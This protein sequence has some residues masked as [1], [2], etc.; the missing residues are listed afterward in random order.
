[1]LL[2]SLLVGCCSVAFSISLFPALLFI[3]FKVGF[4]LSICSR[5]GLLSYLVSFWWVSSLFPWLSGSPSFSSP[6][7][8]F[9]YKNKRN[10]STTL[11][12][13]KGFLNKYLCIRFLVILADLK[14]L[15]LL[16]R[17]KKEANVSSEDGN[18]FH[19]LAQF[20]IA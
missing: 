20:L 10:N 4:R 7:S 17:L 15:T 13:T 9:Y 12:N 3:F 6:S 5:S 19:P 16:S 18:C 2:L 8:I 1:M 11:E 14:E